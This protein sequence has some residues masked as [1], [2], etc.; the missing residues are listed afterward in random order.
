MQQ[1]LHDVEPCVTNFNDWLAPFNKWQLVEWNKTHRYFVQLR[2]TTVNMLNG[3]F[4]HSTLHD[5]VCWSGAATFVDQE[6]QH[7]L[8]RS[9][10]ICWSTNV[11][12][13]VTSFRRLLDWNTNISQSHPFLLETDSK[14]YLLRSESAIFSQRITES[15]EQ[16]KLKSVKAKIWRT[17]WKYGWQVRTPA[18]KA[19]MI[20]NTAQASLHRLWVR[21]WC[22]GYHRG[23]TRRWTIFW[24]CKL[25]TGIAVLL[26]VLCLV[27][28]TW[29]L[30]SF[31][32]R[33]KERLRGKLWVSY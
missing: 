8:N 5:N 7:L 26:A 21:L 28:P 18:F 22:S 3:I 17:V 16:R 20:T 12:P 24:H 31:T 23:S 19:D 15:K 4:Q 11:E 27:T 29:G 6:L 9:C 32:W 14:E 1:M 25:Y 2:S 13:C 33:D 30:R 10:N